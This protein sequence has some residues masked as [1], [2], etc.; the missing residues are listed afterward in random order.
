MKLG[1]ARLND[2]VWNFQGRLEIPRILPL[3][4]IRRIFCAIPGAALAAGYAA[5]SASGV[6]HGI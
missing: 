2:S 3:H 6:V 5:T 4:Q 1:G